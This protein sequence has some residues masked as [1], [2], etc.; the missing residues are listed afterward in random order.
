MSLNMGMTGI[1][2]IQSKIKPER[3]YIG[4]A[5]G[6][7]KRWRNHLSLLKRNKHC[8]PKLQNH[9]NKYG[10]VDL[11]FSILLNC[12]K[13]DLIKI[14]QYFIDSYNPWFNICKI[15]GNQLGIKRSE[16]F[17]IHLKLINLGKIVSKETRDKMSESQL[18]VAGKRRLK[19]IGRKVS[20]ETRSKL[21]DA[22]KRNGSKPPIR[23][24]KRIK[25]IS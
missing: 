15:A 5:M 2:K 3:I 18:K 23:I 11:V 19:M 16:E 14:E 1:Y 22:A 24:S 4:S 21:R 20:E 13:E 6:I 7:F 9:F 12:E 17:K 25:L 10:E 8:S